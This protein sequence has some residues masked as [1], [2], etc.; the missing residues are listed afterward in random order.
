M[1]RLEKLVPVLEG[2][3]YAH[4]F[5]CG[6]RKKHGCMIAYR[7]DMFVKSNE[8]TVFYDEVE[9]RS[10]GVSEQ[11]RIGSS[12]KTK[13]IGLI[14][15][16]TRQDAEASHIVVATTHLFWHPKYT[17]ERAR[18]V[19]F[20]RSSVLWLTHWFRQTYILIQSIEK[21]KNDH[22][23]QDAVSFIAGGISIFLPYLGIANKSMMT[24][25]FNFEPSNAA[26]SLLA[27]DPLTP[28]QEQDI[29]SSHVVHATIDPTIPK[30]DSKLAEE[31]EGGEADPEND[32][33]RVIKNARRATT[34]DGLLDAR[35]L[36]KL[37][38]QQLSGVELKSVYD[39]Y[40]AFAKERTFS[41][42]NEIPL[43]RRGRNEPIY[44]SYTYYW[45]V[46]L[47]MWCYFSLF[48][49]KALDT[50]YFSA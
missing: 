30:E 11:A 39:N 40:T 33:D 20:H 5:A 10:Q 21:F 15:S 43:E 47:G 19:C 16:L 7:K 42:R 31:E 4:T 23:L 46:T 26:Y 22:G 13:N 34:D 14:V 2:A 8:K 41:A 1:D 29:S 27:G 45:K 12:F 36:E 38:A 49:L 24:L 32:P 28:Q 6:P 50:H 9:V 35:E 37:F 48:P 44:T 25:D 3:G 17:Y 18:F